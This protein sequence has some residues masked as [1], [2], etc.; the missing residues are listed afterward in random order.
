M[1]FHALLFFLSAAAVAAPPL[2]LERVRQ[3]ALD[4]QPS[5]TALDAGAEA[6]RQTAAAEGQL[7]DPRLKLGLVN[8]PTDR[9]RLNTEPM[10]QAMVAVEQMLPG[11]DKRA[12]R[13]R[14][15]EIDAELLAAEGLARRDAIRRDAALAFVDVRAAQLSLALLQGLDA[16]TARQVDAARIALAAARGS[17]ADLYAAR[18]LLTQVRD[19]RLE[20][21][22]ELARRRAELGRWIG[23]AAETPVAETAPELP[24][25][26]GLAALRAGLAHHS[27]HAR[28]SVSLTAAEADLALAREALVPDKAIEIGYGRRQ[29][30]FAD[31][32]SIQFAM[33][34]PIAPDNRQRRGIAARERRLDEARLLEE[35][36]LRMQAAELAAAYADW[37]IAGERLAQ[38]DAELLPAAAGRVEAALAAYRAGRGD[39]AAVLEARRAATEAHLAR[40]EIEARLLK[41]RIQLAY[42]EEAGDPHEASH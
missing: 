29:A 3:L 14:R 19:R 13:Q 17:Q 23:A 27:A 32:V 1:R 11:G 8:V 38:A 21:Q 36:H 4:G 40:V 33:D 30:P 39:L 24:P 42:F 18:G 10:T 7:P 9:F 35:D 31:M 37:Q 12:L 41:S 34:L 15:A 5:L 6:A 2:D 20:Q 22:G 16:E 25:P 26:P 28:E